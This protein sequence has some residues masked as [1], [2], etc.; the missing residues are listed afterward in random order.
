M[1]QTVKP[2]AVR[3]WI[4]AFHLLSCWMFVIAVLGKAI[5]F[6]MVHVPVNVWPH[7]ITKSDNR[8]SLA[9][10]NSLCAHQKHYSKVESNNMMAL[11]QRFIYQEW[12]ELIRYM[13]KSFSVHCEMTVFLSR[14]KLILSTYSVCRNMCILAD[15][16][17]GTYI[18]NME[19]I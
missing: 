1:G 11:L 15:G 6:H 13:S 19:F 8:F 12:C 2:N 14:L 4:N 9:Q 10:F 7:R 16:W 17:C 18:Y 3:C 5:Y